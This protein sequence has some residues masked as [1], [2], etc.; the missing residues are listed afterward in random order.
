MVFRFTPVLLMLTLFSA[1]APLNTYYRAGANVA[2][3]SRETTACEVRA[4]RDVPASVQIRRIAPEFVP[5]HRSCDGAG[6]CRIVPGYFIPGETISFDPND[7]L[8]KRVEVQCMADKGFAPVSIP[9]CP[10]A[11]A[12][13]VPRR[14]TATLPALDAKSCVIRNDDGSFQIVTRR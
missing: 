3:L 2:Q 11:L 13:A 5:A 7:G 8:R 1:C 4:L 12:K 9:P 6:N 10:D 14:A